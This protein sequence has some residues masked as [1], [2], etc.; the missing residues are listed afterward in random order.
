[1]GFG[2]YAITTETK[3]IRPGAVTLAVRNGGRLT[4][5]L[6]MKAE[7]ESSGHGGG[8]RFKVEEPSFG[9]GQS[10]KLTLT[11]TPGVYELECYVANHEELGM[12]TILRV[13]D[14]APLVKQAKADGNSVDIRA[15]AF[16]PEALAVPVGTRVTWRNEDPTAHTVT[17]KD[18]SFG[19][20]PL[21]SGTA[22]STTFDQPGEYRYFCA[23]HPTMEGVIRVTG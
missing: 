16:G 2:E 19:S 4:H 21:A 13:G 11:L 14:D 12:L 10:F 18:G 23:I 6:E 17:S 1:M 20:D 15:F 22:F 3:A 5:G 9:P 7:G 8:D